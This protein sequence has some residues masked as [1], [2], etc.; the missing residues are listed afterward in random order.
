MQCI[1]LSRNLCSLAQLSHGNFKI[2]FPKP[3]SNIFG[4]KKNP[5][6]NPKK[7]AKQN[8]N[9]KTPNT[10]KPEQHTHG[11]RL[12]QVGKDRRRKKLEGTNGQATAERG[13]SNAEKHDKIYPF[14]SL[15][16]CYETQDSPA[17][18]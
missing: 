5:Q 6:T 15:R 17:L 12:I 7:P 9:H 4:G 16:L 10:L 14:D 2:D 8:S 13:H 1:H 18:H 11:I 3:N